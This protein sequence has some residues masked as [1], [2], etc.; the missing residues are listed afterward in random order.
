MEKKNNK[1]PAARSTRT[2]ILLY[3]GILYLVRFASQ[4]VEAPLASRIRKEP[5]T[6]VQDKD[7]EHGHPAT[8]NNMFLSFCRAVFESLRS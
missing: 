5:C 7:A 8:E 3:R 6:A 4:P 1:S 2:L